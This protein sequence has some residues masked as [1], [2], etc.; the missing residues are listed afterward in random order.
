MERSISLSV[1]DV[2]EPLVLPP[3]LKVAWAPDM[4]QPYPP[5]HTIMIVHVATGALAPLER[6]VAIPGEPTGLWRLTPSCL[7]MKTQHHLH[8]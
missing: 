2:F 6:L 5:T 4:A 3:C 1:L 8:P 7:L